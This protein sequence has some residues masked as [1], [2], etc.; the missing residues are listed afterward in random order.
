[1][2]T[3]NQLS[4]LKRLK[5]TLSGFKDIYSSNDDLLFLSWLSS[6]G[7]KDI[8]NEYDV[9]V[10]K[11]M[12][13]NFG[14][15]INEIIKGCPDNDYVVIYYEGRGCSLGIDLDF[16]KD[17]DVLNFRM[18]T[19]IF[20]D[21]KPSLCMVIKMKVF[22]KVLFD[23]IF[24]P[25]FYEDLDFIRRTTQHKFSVKNTDIMG[26]FCVQRNN[27]IKLCAKNK[28]LFNVKGSIQPDMRSK[29]GAK[30]CNAC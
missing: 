7:P 26:N 21:Y 9:N 18:N 22:D 8:S 6:N 1:V 27:T 14:H 13:D 24:E 5:D 20:E 30:F 17:F 25:E 15:S 11:A 29:C 4:D 23:N 28:T 16:N 10:R 2:H 3:E 19:P 12:K